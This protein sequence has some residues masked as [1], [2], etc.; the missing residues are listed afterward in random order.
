MKKNAE[1]VGTRYRKENCD[2]LFKEM[3]KNGKLFKNVD[4]NMTKKQMSD[5][6]IVHKLFEYEPVW[7][8]AKV[9]HEDNNEYDLWY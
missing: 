7:L 1:V 6:W 4:Y 8:K 5:I 2:L 3:K 9:E